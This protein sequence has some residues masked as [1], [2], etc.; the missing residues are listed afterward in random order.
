MDLHVFTGCDVISSF[1]DKAK[2]MKY[3]QK[4]VSFFKVLGESYNFEELRKVRLCDVWE[5]S[6]K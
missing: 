2:A 3:Q 1:A 5:T 4:C 6:S